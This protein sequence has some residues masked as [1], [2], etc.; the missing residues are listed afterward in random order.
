MGEIRRWVL[1]LNGVEGGAGVFFEA[2][3]GGAGWGGPVVVYCHSH[4]GRYAVGKEEVLVGRR[5]SSG[6]G[7]RSWCGA[8]HAVLAIDHWA[9][10]ERKPPVGDWTHSSD[11]VAGAGDVGDDGVRFAQGDGLAG[12]AGGRGHGEGGDAGDVDGVDDGVV[13]GGAGRAGEGVRGRVL[14]D[15]YSGVVEAGNLKGHGV[16]YFVPGVMKRFT[17]GEI[18]G[19]IVPRGASGVAGELDGLTPV[20]GSDRTT[21]ELKGAYEELGGGERWRL[22]GIRWGIRRRRRCGGR[23]W[24]G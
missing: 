23:R 6:R 21:T 10:G 12:D 3:G 4:G 17:C 18:N 15:G 16:Y 8:G 7:G 14:F 24:G 11:V 5:T 22:S 20:K 19:L 9:F 1:D 13:G 2:G